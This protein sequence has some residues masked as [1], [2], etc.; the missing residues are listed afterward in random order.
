MGKP[1]PNG[2]EFTSGL[3]ELEEFNNEDRLE[4]QYAGKYSMDQESWNINSLY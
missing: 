2:H 1:K 4:E 3:S